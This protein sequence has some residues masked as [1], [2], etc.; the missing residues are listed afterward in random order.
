MGLMRRDGIEEETLGKVEDDVLIEKPSI[1]ATS[2]E[3]KACDGSPLSRVVILREQFKGDPAIC[4]IRILVDNDTVSCCLLG[5]SRDQKNKKDG[6]I[7]GALRNT[8]KNWNTRE[9]AVT[10]T[11]TLGATRKVGCKPEQGISSNST[12]SCQGVQKNVVIDS[13]KGSRQVEET[14]GGGQISVSIA[15]KVIVE[16]EKR[17]LSGIIRAI[18]RLTIRKKVESREMSRKLVVDN[19]FNQFRHKGEASN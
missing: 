17:S 19:T 6:T 18:G 2:P 12:A 9:E 13:I 1:S 4:V 14:D 5:K 11:N 8:N 10:N 3:T 15:E 16:S 7:D